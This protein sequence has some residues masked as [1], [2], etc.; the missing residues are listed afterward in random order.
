MLSV[1]LSWSLPQVILVFMFNIARILW[2][3]QNTIIFIFKSLI[4]SNRSNPDQT[5]SYSVSVHCHHM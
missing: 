4:F 3:Y 5:L 1:Q 2:I